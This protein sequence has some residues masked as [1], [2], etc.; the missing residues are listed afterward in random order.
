MVQKWLTHFLENN[1][2]LLRAYRFQVL[3]V[4]K[5]F[6]FEDFDNTSD[7]KTYGHYIE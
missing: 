4:F 7:K 1:L 6:A 2:N 3:S 5:Y